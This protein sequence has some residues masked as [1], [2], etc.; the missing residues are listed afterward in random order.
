MPRLPDH[1][2]T[3]ALLQVGRREGAGGLLLR[4]SV[5]GAARM[6]FLYRQTTRKLRIE[7]KSKLSMNTDT[8]KTM[9][10]FIST[11]PRAHLDTVLNL[12]AKVGPND[13]YAEPDPARPDD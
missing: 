4:P 3:Q 12:G 11:L 10:I 6:L 2:Q 8:P 9:K 5:E 7:L 1:P 13:D